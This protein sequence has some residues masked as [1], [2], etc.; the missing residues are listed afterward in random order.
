VSAEIG[1]GI[2]QNDAGRLPVAAG[3]A[4]FLIIALDAARQRG[5]NHGPNIGFVDAHAECDGGNDDLQLAGSEQSLHPITLLRRHPGMIGGGGKFPLQ[6]QAKQFGF[7]AGWRVDDGRPP[8]RIGQ[9]P[10]DGGMA[11]RHPQFHRLDR[12]IGPAKAVDVTRCVAHGKLPHDVVLDQ[13]GRGGGQGD[14]RRWPQQ[15]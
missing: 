4:D 9:N 5:V 13:D 6:L 7:L 8:T 11:L 3:A 10:P 12:Q 2:E 15:G 14:H 1:I